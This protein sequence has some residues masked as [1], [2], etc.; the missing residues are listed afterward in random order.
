[1]ERDKFIAQGKEFGFSGS[2]LKEYVDECI[3]EASDERAETRRAE[4]DARKEQADL[5][6]QQIKLEELRNANGMGH[7]PKVGN[8]PCIPP[9]PVFQEGKDDIDS[10]LCRF[11][12][13]ASCVGWDKED[14]AL[15]LSAL[16]SGKAL[17]IVSRLTSEQVQD[18]EIVKSSLLKGYDLTQEGYRLKFKQAKLRQGETFVQYASRIEKYLD[19]WIELSPYNDD[20]QGLK[21]LLIQDQVFDACSK[22]LLM[23]VKERQPRNL[24]EVLSLADQY[25]D[26]HMDPR[27]RRMKDKPIHSS[28]AQQSSSYTANTTNSG[29][30]KP[31]SSTGA[32]PFRGKS[33]Q[34]QSPMKRSMKCFN[35]SQFG[36]SSWNCPDKKGRQEKGASF[37]EGKPAAG[38]P[39][40]TGPAEPRRKEPSE[41]THLPEQ[42]GMCLIVEPSPIVRE[43]LTDNGAA[44]K[45]ATGGTLPVLSAAAC[46][47]RGDAMPVC[48]G[49]V[50]RRRVEVL[51]DSGCS[52]VVVRRNLVLEEQFTGEQRT[53]V[54]IDGTARTY[55]VAVVEVDTPYLTG[56]LEALCMDSPV[57]DLILGNVNGVRE[58]TNPDEKWEPESHQASALET[59]GQK[60]QAKRA[61]PALLVPEPLESIVSVD[62]LVQ[63][64]KDDESLKSLR[65]LA[66]LGDQRVTKQGNTTS[67][68][69]KSNVLYRKF[70]DVTPGS[71]VVMQ[72]VVPSKFR[73][74]VMKLAHESIFGG[75]L[76]NKKTCD[77]IQSNF[78][79]PGMHADVGRYCRSCGPCQRTSPKGKVTKVPLGS[80]PLID[81]P[82]RRVAL[83]II[84]PIEPAT[85]KGNRFILTVVDYATRYPEAVALR[86]IDT[87]TVAEA[88]V[89]IYSRVGIP[90]EVL[91]DRGSQFTS[92]VMKEVSRLLSTRQ[93]T[94]TPYH[95]QCNGLVER[96]NGTL[97][98]MLRKM[99]EE[100]PKDW[101]RYVNP[102]L[103]AYRESVQEST[104]FSPFELLFGR[105]VRGPLTILRELWTGEVEEPETKTTYQY[106]LDLKDRLEATC[107]LA[108][109]NL[110]LSAEKYRKQYNRK[111]KHRKFEVG[112]EVLLLLPSDRNK[113]L[114]H[115]QG[116]FKVV[117]RVGYLVYKIDMDGKVKTFHANLLK[118][119]FRRDNLDENDVACVSVVDDGTMDEDDGENTQ[120]T[121]RN[122]L[123]HL[124]TLPPTESLQDVQI[125]PE[126]DEGQRGTINSVLEEYQETL[127]DMPGLTT[128]GKH[129]IKLLSKEPIKSKPYPLPHALRGEV[130]K[131]VKKMIDLGVVEPSLS[132]YASPIVM[133]KKK[134]GSIRFCCDYRKLN[135]VTVTDAEP[136]A[137]QEEI[138][139]KLAND[140][141]FT[142]IDL[143]KGYWQVPLTENAKELTAFVTSD[144]LYQFSTMP[145][146]LVNAPASLSRIMRDLLRGLSNVDNFIDDILI[147]TATFEEHIVTLNEVLRRLRQANLT[148]RPTK[149]FIGYRSVEFLGHCVGQGELRPVQDKV[150]AVKNAPRPRTKKQ[151]RSFLGLVGYYRRFIPN[152]AAIAA[153]LT[154]RTKKGEPTVIRWG[155]AEEMAFNTLKK[156]LEK[157][158]ILHLPDLDA[159]FILRT[160][161]SDIGLGAILLQERD[162]RKFP[163]AYASRK[164]L[165]REQ[166]YSVMERECLAIIWATQK[167]EAYLFG[168]H[169]ELET[170]HQPLKCIARSKV[171]NARILRWALALQPYRFTITAIKSS[172]NVG[173]DYLSRIPET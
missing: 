46:G 1:M 171:A 147:H 64:Q 23:F 101:D 33:G 87:Q 15:A 166:R 136:L 113:L 80:T 53:C 56:T 137:D 43:N 162:G 9:L 159:P 130:T 48:Q 71:D 19:R 123:L 13:H 36:H 86:R 117:Q 67:F 163:V 114:M 24:T 99:C 121:A 169:F 7:R 161:A 98:A 138:F 44:V 155:D 88:L 27:I 124:P 83:D 135:Q 4:T 47:T 5:I 141:Y 60:R 69:Y 139:A 132:P 18:Y 12:R 17:D 165:P 49:M 74:Q 167:F 97:K 148:A 129:D 89:N 90:R 140:M 105:T 164:L 91:T 78:F 75:H 144:G 93:M 34:S 45:L 120:P 172:E 100:K 170:D 63:A 104:G 41:T 103:F 58:P 57:Y 96:F 102:L 70:L 32:V 22:E 127:T 6:A 106:V 119:F 111:A 149:C 20:V 108:Q 16:L 79:W 35:C 168:K 11:E 3:K 2:E 55:P 29:T 94:T 95:P 146:G 42:T 38:H 37:T 116:P 145:I 65:N 26:A 21:A 62:G 107:K 50:N 77:R 158:P 72:V 142:K 28:G 110:G 109:E 128:L 25:R 61:Q 173:A 152:F 112:D 154:D 85:G 150:K 30:N 125:N 84:G 134:D 115:W 31:N 10:Y 39:Q 133:V 54:L 59:R 157:E 122:N 68:V 126:L 81:E 73:N 66:E 52:T 151:L 160:D 131:E 143:A 92:D 76:G 8:K 51:R 40:D 118:R 156:K 153:P 82:F 14:W